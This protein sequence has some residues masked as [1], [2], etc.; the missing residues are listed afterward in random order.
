MISFR[1]ASL[2]GKGAS[3]QTRSV[4]TSLVLNST[5]IQ[6]DRTVQK[7]SKPKGHL[8][9]RKKQEI[10]RKKLHIKGAH[11]KV[12]CHQRRGNTAGVVAMMGVTV[13][14]LPAASHPF[15]EAALIGTRYYIYCE[16]VISR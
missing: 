10:G 12:P 6:Y 4:T 9:V 16:Y 7:E 3:P 1:A 13:S 15:N 14:A 5:Y 11:I 2:F 8:L